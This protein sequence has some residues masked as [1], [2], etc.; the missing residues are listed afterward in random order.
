MRVIQISDTHLSRNKPHFD[1]NWAPLA[2]W[3]AALRPDLVLH[4]GDVSVDG[5]EVDDDLAYAAQLLAGLPARCRA[6]PG[7]HDVGEAGHRRHPVDD[8]RLARWR[9]RFGEDRWVEDVPGWRLI[10]LDALILG[11]GGIEEAAQTA[12]LETIMAECV[13]P[14]VAWFLHK[15]LFLDSPREGDTGY[16]AVQPGPR[17]PLLALLER[18]QVALVASGHL[19]KEHDFRS[20]QTRYIWGPASS[21][22]VG[23]LQPEMPGA[24]RLG[25]VLYEFGTAGFT[26]EICEVPGLNPHCSKTWPTKCIRDGPNRRVEPPRSDQ[27]PVDFWGCH[28]RLPPK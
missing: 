25:A 22:L 21:F 9:A 7:N 11:Q 18:H 14:R 19:H 16:W 24:K 20:N 4:T 15:P 5:A 6:V 3:I 10:G 27:F 8:A 23:N 26:A 13:A 17:A 12:W 28:Q 2:R 1:D